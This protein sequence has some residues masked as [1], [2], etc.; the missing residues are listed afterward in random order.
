M[1]DETNGLIEQLDKVNERISTTQELI[2]KH[3]ER[4]TLKYILDGL[5]SHKASIE[6]QPSPPE[7]TQVEK[8]VQDLLDARNKVGRETYGKGLDHSDLKWNWYDM[9]LEACMNLDL[10]C[11]CIDISDQCVPHY[12]KRLKS[13]NTKLS[14]NWT[15]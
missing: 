1:T 12:K 2:H 15:T 4:W 7:Q 8:E 14:D 9:A 13:D 10:D 5:Y 11:L 6:D 3:P